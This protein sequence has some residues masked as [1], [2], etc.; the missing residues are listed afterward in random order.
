[1]T[2]DRFQQ[3]IIATCRYCDEKHETGLIEYVGSYPVPLEGTYMLAIIT[4]WGAYQR[5]VR[6]ELERILEEY[7]LSEET[8]FTK[9]GTDC[10]GRTVPISRPSTLSG[11]EQV[12]IEVY[13]RPLKTPK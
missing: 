3:G 11:S 9:E 4:R 10:G 7:G 12:F 6:P 2:P 5:V 1:M 13:L 8:R